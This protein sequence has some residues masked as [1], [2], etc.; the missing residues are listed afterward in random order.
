MRELRCE[1]VGEGGNLGL[2]QPARVEFALLGGRIG[3]GGIAVA[4]YGKAIPRIGE[5][6]L[7]RTFS[8]TILLRNARSEA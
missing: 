8:E 2:T 6:R 1:V 5:A 7:T 4:L 3:I